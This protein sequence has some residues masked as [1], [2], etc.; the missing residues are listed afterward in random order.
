MNVEHYMWQEIN[1]IPCLVESNLA[2]FSERSEIDLDKL[3]NDEI[4]SI[5]ILASGSSYNAGL[6]SKYIFEKLTGIPTMVNFASEFA[7]NENIIPS[8]TAYITISQSGKTFDT[9]ESLQK[10][11]SGTTCPTFSI[12]NVKGSELYN[13]ATYKILIGAGQEKAIPATK[14]FTMQL[15]SLMQLAILLAKEIQPKSDFIQ[16]FEQELRYIPDLILSVIKKHLEIKELSAELLSKD[17]LV[18]LSTGINYA[19]AKEGALKL[20][21]TTYFDCNAHP[22]GEFMHGYMAI[23]D[24]NTNLIVFDYKNESNISHNVKKL[25]SKCG[26]QIFGIVYPNNNSNFEVYDK[27]FTLPKANNDALSIFAYTTF[28]QILSYY[29][30]CYLGYNPDKPRG[31]T[32][33]LDKE[34]GK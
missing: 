11:Q 6:A 34:F 26:S 23:M 30:A 20:K 29:G 15:L 12:T 25:K 18:I 32:K 14:T 28:I 27:I 31:L 10:I 8:N 24:K 2:S 33:F 22:I 7:F 16:T 13:K 3:K 19:I 17:H 1:Q 9:V 4:R 21:E 5:Q